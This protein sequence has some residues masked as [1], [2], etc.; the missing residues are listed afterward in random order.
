MST[1]ARLRVERSDIES[2]VEHLGHTP[3]CSSTLTGSCTCMLS[4]LR[5]RL[6]TVLRAT[7]PAEPTTLAVWLHKK[8]Y[9]CV[10]PY[11]SDQAARNA[12][13]EIGHRK[14]ATE[15]AALVAQGDIN[16]PSATPQP[17]SGLGDEGRL[18]LPAG[19]RDHE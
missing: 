17:V 10:S 6:S 9:G 11:G 15:L 7:E 2:A 19:A 13:D 8:H 12:Y 18:D 1:D 16:A 4:S 5:S 14:D 3:T